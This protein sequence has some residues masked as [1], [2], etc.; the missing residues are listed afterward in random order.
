MISVS[1]H[2]LSKRLLLKMALDNMVV[3]TVVYIQLNKQHLACREVELNTSI[4]YYEIA[5]RS[6][7]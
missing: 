7:V 6:N 5:I 3:K 1:R 4:F 2:K